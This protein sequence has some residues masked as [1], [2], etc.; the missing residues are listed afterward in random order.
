M[1]DTNGD[2]RDGHEGAGDERVRP[3]A[4][5]SVEENANGFYW[6]LDNRMHTTGQVDVYLRLKDGKFE[7]L[8]TLARG[9][10]GVTQDDA[11]RIYRNTNE[12]ALHVD[13]VP[14]AY[15]ARNPNLLR[16]RGSYEALRDEDNAINTVWPVRPNPGTNR[17]Y[18]TGIDR[19]GRHAG[20]VHGGLRAAGVP[21][22]SAAGGALRQRRSSPSRPPTSS[23]ASS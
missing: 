22:R 12:S 23:A 7:V 16:T 10:W 15:F 9:E 1:R 11:G 17:A 6:G 20:Q 3:A 13:F 19:A 4:R 8:K 2:L 5:A 21:R 14:T 18:Q